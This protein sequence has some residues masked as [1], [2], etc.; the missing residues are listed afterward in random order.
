MVVP[1]SDNSVDPSANTDAF[2]AFTRATPEE[3]VA[4]SR[5]PLIVGGAVAAVM[6]VA[7]IAWLAL[8]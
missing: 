6:L 1:M 4:A 2:Q 5:A 7:L 8:S 3:T